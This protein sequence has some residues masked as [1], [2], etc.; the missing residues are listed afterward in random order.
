MPKLKNRTTPLTKDQIDAWFN[1][2]LPYLRVSLTNHLRVCE[3]PTLFASM[4]EQ[5]RHR[6]RVCAYESGVLT[7]R[8]FIEFLGLSIKYNPYRLVE[9][10]EY[11]AALEDRNSYEVK[12]IDLGGKWVELSKLTDQ[13]RELLQKIYLTGHRATVHLTDGSPY[14]GESEIFH[15]AVKLVDRLLKEH[16]FDVVGKTPTIH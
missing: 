9:Q 4:S 15:D 3:E 7:C 6:A 13:E 8:K 10:R 12:V 5:E 1:A 16:L 11:Y 14:Q 2:H